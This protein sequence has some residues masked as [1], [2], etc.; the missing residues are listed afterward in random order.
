[1]I[2]TACL[3]F[4]DEQPELLHRCISQLAAVGIDQLVAV[5]GPYALYPHEQTR[6]TPEALDA[7]RETTHDLGIN[8]LLSGGTH[9]WEGNEVEKRQHMITLA[10]GAHPRKKWN[11][12]RA[13][14]NWLLVV[15]ADHFWQID[16]G[17]NLHELLGQCPGAIDFAAV[18]FAEVFQ[19]NGAPIY[20]PARPLMRARWDLRM[21]TNHYTYETSDGFS[22]FLDRPVSTKPA[23]NLRNHVRVVHGVHDRDPE[24][25]GRQITYYDGRDAGR[26][27]A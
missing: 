12:E 23:L 24:R 27:E 4:F 1:V 13:E 9:A 11:A 14:R 17:L 5:D 16:S 22:T 25:R 6:S 10:R 26:V 21:G 2:I 8:L 19:P 18:S 20:A 3:S 15:D 7:I